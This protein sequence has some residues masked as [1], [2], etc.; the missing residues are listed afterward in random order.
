MY[1]PVVPEERLAAFLHAPGALLRL[2][3]GTV[4]DTALLR[5]Y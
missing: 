1:G 4:K 5:R 2:Y 3:Y